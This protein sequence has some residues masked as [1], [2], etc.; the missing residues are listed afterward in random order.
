MS[1]RWNP[2]QKKTPKLGPKTPKGERQTL[3]LRT[4][5]LRKRKEKNV[6]NVQMLNIWTND[7]TGT[8]YD[9]WQAYQYSS[10]TCPRNIDDVDNVVSSKTNDTNRSYLFVPACCV[11]LVLRHL[12]NP[13]TTDPE[14][15]TISCPHSTIADETQN[16][17]HNVIIHFVH[18]TMAVINVAL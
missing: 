10:L 2:E 4:L 9:L 7:R 17:R 18:L 15:H 5:L 16:I 14:R 13:A 12:W 8:W 6:W 3:Q 1:E 11:G